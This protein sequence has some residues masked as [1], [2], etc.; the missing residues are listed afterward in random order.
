MYL[1]VIMYGND[2]ISSIHSWYSSLSSVYLLR[3]IEGIL[4]PLYLQNSKYSL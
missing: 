1:F 3:W 2:H 4:L